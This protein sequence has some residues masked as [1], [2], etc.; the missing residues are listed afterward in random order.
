MSEADHNSGDSVSQDGS[1]SDSVD[2]SDVSVEASAQV[3]VR[4]EENIADGNNELTAPSAR[5]LAR[6]ERAE[7]PLFWKVSPSGDG[8]SIDQLQS[9]QRQDSELVSL[10]V[11]GKLRE[12]PECEAVIRC[13]KRSSI[14]V[15]PTVTPQ[16]V[17]SLDLHA[18]IDLHR[19]LEREVQALPGELVVH[20][21]V[22]GVATTLLIDTGASVSILSTKLWDEIHRAQPG[23]TLL[24]TQVRVR[25][26]SGDLVN[27]RGAVVCE[28]EL[29]KRYYMHRFLVM[30]TVKDIILGL[31]FITRYNL[32]W[33]KVHGTLSVDPRPAA[34]FTQTF[35]H[36]RRLTVCR[37][38]VVP[39][40]PRKIVPVQL[41]GPR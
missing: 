12:D 32:A 4:S 6:S 18:L 1:V 35:G 28:I 25:T 34:R 31:D 30:D 36:L 15:G 40:R 2:Q 29:D 38:T 33:N 16:G 3:R 21:R 7:V 27:A 20:A 5:D 19:K 13:R 24:P 26:V 22:C 39:A 14:T 8:L 11:L 37:R 10:A 17:E 9:A 23:L 41:Q